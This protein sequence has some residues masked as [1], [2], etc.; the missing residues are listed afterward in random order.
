MVATQKTVNEANKDK[1][2]YKLEVVFDPKLGMQIKQ[3]SNNVG[4]F[5]IMGALSVVHGIHKKFFVDEFSRQIGSNVPR[6]TPDQQ[7]KFDEAM[8]KTND[9][10]N[11]SGE[12]D[13]VNRV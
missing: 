7:K 1:R 12:G 9:E 13:G 5:D 3:D 10:L 6:P 2:F 8:K 11:K 4:P